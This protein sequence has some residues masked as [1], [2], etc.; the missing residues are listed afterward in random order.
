MAEFALGTGALALFLAALF[1]LG[2]FA[3]RL[4]GFNDG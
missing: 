2:V 1:A 4:C 3:G